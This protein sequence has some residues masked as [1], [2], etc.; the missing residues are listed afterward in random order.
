LI[1]DGVQNT[2]K[3][4]RCDREN[5]TMHWK[6]SADGSVQHL[7]TGL[8]ID[9][10]AST[11]GTTLKLAPCADKMQ[12]RFLLTTQKQLRGADGTCVQADGDSLSLQECTL[13][14]RQLDW[15]PGM[16]P[17]FVTGLIEGL[18]NWEIPD[19]ISY[20]GSLSFGDVD[21]D[22]DDDLCVR[23]GDGVY[24]AFSDG[25]GFSSFA[26]V[27]DGFRDDQG[28]FAAPYGSTV[29]L[30]DIDG[31]GA[32]EICGRGPDG[33]YCADWNHLTVAFDPPSLRSADFNDGQGY[34]DAASRYRS[35]RI[36]DLDRDGKGD[37]CARSAGGIFCAHSAGNTYSPAKLWA[38]EEFTD[39]KGWSREEYGSTLRF[40]D[41]DG[42]GDPDVCGRS[43]DGI[44]CARND[45]GD[46]FVDPHLWSHTG[47]FGDGNGWNKQ[48]SYYGSIRLADIDRDGNVDVCGRGPSGLLCSL[49][50]TAAFTAA[51]SLGSAD[52]FSDNSGWQL[53]RYGST[54]GLLDLNLD[55][56]ADLCAWGP[57]YDGKVGLNC[58]LAD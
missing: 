3:L 20:Y 31:D 47:D 9:A 27:L 1:G 16:Y 43:K 17:N 41:I 5:R 51:N 21:G 39:D 55:G 54:L 19:W 35:L 18:T 12:Q 26:R 29:Q 58:S 38:S 32:Q 8:C 48:R 28:W 2:V 11:R 44:L 24:C 10:G 45:G 34:G 30:G 52:A 42:D 23:R 57:G 46:R 40:G 15:S 49:S 7:G 4:A 6:V 33:V 56:F 37:L 14:V 13:D 25:A 53:D 50:T 36:V 22:G